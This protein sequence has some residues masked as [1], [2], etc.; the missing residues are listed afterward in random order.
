MWCNA[1]QGA[2]DTAHTYNNNDPARI[3]LQKSRIDLQ[4]TYFVGSVLKGY[5]ARC[6]S[7]D[8]KS[9]REPVES[10]IGRTFGAKDSFHSNRLM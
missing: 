9:D 5:V 2:M 3:L 6:R 10:R 7:L 4:V 1:M 8:F